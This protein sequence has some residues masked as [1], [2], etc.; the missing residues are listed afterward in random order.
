MSKSTQ[1]KNGQTI[2]IGSSVILAKFT[3]DDNS[4]GI[5]YN[6]NRMDA[7]VGKTGTVIDI[8]ENGSDVKW[9]IVQIEDARDL[10]WTYPANVLTL[11]APAVGKLAKALEDAK[12]GE[13]VV[14]PNTLY[15]PENL[16][17][18]EVIK[19]RN[20]DYDGDVMVAYD[21][22]VCEG[23]SYFLN[24]TKIERDETDELRRTTKPEIDMSVYADLCRFAIREYPQGKRIVYSSNDFKTVSA[25]EAQKVFSEYVLKAIT[26]GKELPV[27]TLQHLKRFAAK[28]IT[29]SA[30][31]KTEKQLRLRLANQQAALTKL[32]AFQ[33]RKGAKGESS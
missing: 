8:R 15:I 7:F 31:K 12:F 18:K 6:A 32:I 19:L 14:M 3:S 23:C 29:L 16:R 17:N 2:V 11:A 13:T 21:S 28:F 26:E 4:H 20:K 5:Y 22:G 9:V 25:Y 24:L 30:E 27:G 33:H 1:G 10:D